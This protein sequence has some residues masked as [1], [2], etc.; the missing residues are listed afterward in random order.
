[1]QEIQSFADLKKFVYTNL[2]EDNQLILE[3]NPTSE[4]IFWRNS[5]MCGALFCLRGPRAVVF[6]AAWDKE[7][8]QVL[9]YRATGYRYKEIQLENNTIEF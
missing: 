1:M 6:S 2:C 3:G 9:F 5:E 7:Q 4:Q 8:N